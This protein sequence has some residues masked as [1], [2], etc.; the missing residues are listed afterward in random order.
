M[1]KVR[2]LRGS[3]ISFSGLVKSI[4]LQLGLSFSFTLSSDSPSRDLMAVM[5]RSFSWRLLK[6]SLSQRTFSKIF[7]ILRKM[8]V[9]VGFVGLQISITQNPKIMPIF[10]SVFNNVFN[11]INIKY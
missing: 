11:Y 1:T 5:L 10:I 3:S 8:L 4:Y 6:N 7:A 9:H 2:K